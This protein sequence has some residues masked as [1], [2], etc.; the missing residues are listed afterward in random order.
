MGENLHPK[1]EAPCNIP[2]NTEN[3]WLVM[4]L[5]TFRRGRPP[6]VAPCSINLFFVTNSNYDVN[7]GL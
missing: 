6:T 7:E 3:I 2:Y 1:D 4:F 5:R